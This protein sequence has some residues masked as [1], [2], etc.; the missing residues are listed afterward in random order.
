MIDR[1]SIDELAV[2]V[3][4]SVMFMDWRDERQPFDDVCPLP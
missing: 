2:V 4:Y 1:R 3:V